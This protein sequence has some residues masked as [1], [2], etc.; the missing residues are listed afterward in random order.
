MNG[1]QCSKCLE[2]GLEWMI[3]KAGNRYLAARTEIAGETRSVCAVIYP[4]H[5]CTD[6]AEL[7]NLRK[8]A[9][10]ERLATGALI[11]GQTVTVTRGRKVAVGTEGKIF[12]VTPQHDG[13]GVIK[14]GVID[15]NGVK[16]YV[17]IEYLEAT[18][19]GE[20]A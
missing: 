17:N 14:A 5:R 8:Q 1:V 11:K 18:N 10:Q 6:D 4:A 16:H 15:T 19:K 12:W 3:S 20:E 2:D 7:I 13:Y 9:H